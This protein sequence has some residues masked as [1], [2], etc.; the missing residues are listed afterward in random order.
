MAAE[1][2][3][4]S[5]TYRAWENGKGDNAGP[6]RDQADHLNRALRRLLAGQYSDGE[7]FDAWGWPRQQDMSYDRV[8]ELLRFAGFSVP[9]T[10]ANVQPPARVFWP[11]KVREANLVHGVFSLAA[12]AA[13]GPA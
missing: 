5:A 13:P 9:R 3:V 8:A 12:A 6:T 4:S 1:I 7:A 10:Q 2:N 11:H